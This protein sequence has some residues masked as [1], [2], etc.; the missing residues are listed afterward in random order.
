MTHK[1]LVCC[2]ICQDWEGEH[3]HFYTPTPEERREY[4]FSEKKLS[5]TYCPTCFVLQMKHDGLKLSEFEEII[6]KVEGK[7]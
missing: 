5:H 3:K 4:F 7:K 2:S 6:K 1:Y